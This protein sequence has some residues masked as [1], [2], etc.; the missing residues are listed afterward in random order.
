MEI[1]IRGRHMDV[2]TKFK[3]FADE[4]LGR[5]AHF[6]VDIARIDV[7]VSKEGN[8]RL[9]DRA[10]EVELTCHSG[11]RGPLLRAEAHAPDKFSALDVACDTM[12]ERLRRLADKRRTKRRRAARLVP[13]DPTLEARDLG[14]VEA[15][16]IES[17]GEAP[18]EIVMADGPMIIRLKTHETQPMTVLGALDAMEMVGHDFYFFFDSEASQPS[19]V[20]RRRGYDYGLIRLDVS[21]DAGIIG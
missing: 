7:E 6:G 12:T 19:V 14:T 16:P 13:S 9:A 21:D 5:L 3:E 1:V 11:R 8:P 2:S 17:D 20:Y 10:I 18:D 4:K 15:L